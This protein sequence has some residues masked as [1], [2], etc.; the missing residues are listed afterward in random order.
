MQRLIALPGPRLAALTG[1]GVALLVGGGW[2]ALT[3]ATGKT[4][5]LAPLLG[6]LA[7]ALTPRA[8][9]GTRLGATSGLVLGS[10][11]A[12]LMLGAWGLIVALDIQ[13]GATLADNIPGEVFGEVVIGAVLGFAISGLLHA[14]RRVGE[15][16]SQ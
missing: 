8:V 11:G 9:F 10:V 1:I 14:Q 16:S 5:H 2:I 15:R 3:A 13:P 6:A 4:Y 12:A 7:P